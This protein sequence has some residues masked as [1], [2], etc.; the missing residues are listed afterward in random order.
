[1]ANFA[2]QVANFEK[3]GTFNYKFDE[4]G[5]VILNPKGGSVF[6]KNNSIRIETYDSYIRSFNASP[7]K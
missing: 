7:Q 3:Y 1:M 6:K 2:L 4:A 5:N